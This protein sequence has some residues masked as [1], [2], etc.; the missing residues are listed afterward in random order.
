MKR[1]EKFIMKAFIVF[2]ETAVYWIVGWPW[3]LICMNRA[4]GAGEAVL[5]R[6]A[7]QRGTEKARFCSQAAESASYT[8]WAFD[9]VILRPWTS[10]IHICNMRTGASL[11]ARWQRVCLQCRKLGFNPWVGKIPWRRKWQPTLGFLPGKSPGQRRL[12][13]YRVLWGLNKLLCENCA[14]DILNVQ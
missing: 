8:L 6:E 10:N 13:G 1:E 7:V 4:G 5:F 3:P 2:W 11:G 12:M 14:Q 9:Q